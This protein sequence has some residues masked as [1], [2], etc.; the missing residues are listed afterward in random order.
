MKKFS[1]FILSLLIVAYTMVS[2][3]KSKDTTPTQTTLQKIEG[4]WLLETFIYHEH[5]TQSPTFDSTDTYVGTASDYFDF[6]N[7]GQVYFSPTD[8][9]SYAVV[10]DTT[11]IITLIG[12]FKIQSLTDHI[13]K[14]NHREN[15]PTSTTGAYAEVTINLKK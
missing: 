1:L 3:S 15:D 13:L 8:S 5:G 6:K 2:C 9:S 10:G 11:L 4:K 12:D 7:N 14:L